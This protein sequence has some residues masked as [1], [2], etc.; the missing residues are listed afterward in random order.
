MLLKFLSPSLSA[1]SFDAE[2][3]EIAGMQRA[4]LEKV[5]RPIG[6]YD[7][8]IAGQALRRNWTLV[9]ANVSEFSRIKGLTWEDWS[10]G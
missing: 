6:P 9:T 5:G 7:L 3:A 4:A 1:V 10:R 2:D 8:L